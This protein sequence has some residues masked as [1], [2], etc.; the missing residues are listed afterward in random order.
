MT[1]STASHV[2]KVPGKCGGKPCVAGT[3]IRVWD[4]YV[5]HELQGKSADE[6]VAAYPELSLADVYAALAYYFDHKLEIDTEMKAADEYAEE[7][8]QLLGPGPLA[9]KLLSMGTSG[10]SVSS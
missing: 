5:L 8:K 9:K 2:E 4:I 10:A 3:R 1:T 6:V 7:V